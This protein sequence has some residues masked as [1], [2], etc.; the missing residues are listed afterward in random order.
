MAG[1]LADK[2]RDRTKAYVRLRCGGCGARSA[3]CCLIPMVYRLLSVVF[4]IAGLM[5]Y[6]LAMPIIIERMS[7]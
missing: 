2:F 1:R 3:V 7:A 4:L 6:R 5:V